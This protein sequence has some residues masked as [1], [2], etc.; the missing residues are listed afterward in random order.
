L[1]YLESADQP[2]RKIDGFIAT[3]KQKHGEHRLP[4]KRGLK[5][6]CSN[7]ALP[8]ANGLSEVESVVAGA[9]SFG[10]LVT[11]HPPIAAIAAISALPSLPDL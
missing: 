7:S 4:C 11:R 5:S 8:L 3:G 10:C 6:V 9:G 2:E 1:A